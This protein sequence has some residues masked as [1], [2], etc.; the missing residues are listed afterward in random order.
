MENENITKLPSKVIL[1]AR[2]SDKR[3]D[4]ED[5]QLMNMRKFAAG[6]G[7]KKLDERKIQESSTKAYRKKFQE[8]ISEI[9]ASK[10]PVAL[11][12]DTVDRLQRSF[13]ESVT[14]DALR[15]ERRVEL[16]FHR[17]NLVIRQ[18]SN[19]TDLMR[20]DMAVMFARNYVLTLGDN[21]KRKFKLMRAEHMKTGPANFGYKPV[22]EIDVFGKRKRIDIIPDPETA[23]LKGS[24]RH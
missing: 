3:Q 8:I 12:V 22:H 13:Y 16:Y 11:I 15:K 4:S 2:V 14:L 9:K 5:A 6:F 21:V 24:P 18:D 19:S 1:L 17:E 20:W 10:E 7:F 23:P